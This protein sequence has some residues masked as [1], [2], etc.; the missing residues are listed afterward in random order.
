MSARTDWEMH[1][2]SEAAVR[3]FAARVRGT[4]IQP[5]DEEYDPARRVWNAAVDRHPALLVRPREVPDVIEAVSFARTYDLPLAVR[6]G[7]HSPAGYGTADL[8]LVVDLSAMKRLDVD[9]DRRV[10]SAEAG[11]TWGEYNARAHEKGLATPGGDVGAVGI[12]GLTL[13]GGMG[14]L[15][16]KHG[17]TIDNLVEVDIVTTDGRRLTA[18]A[19]AEQDLFWALRGGGGNFGIA[20]GFRYRL[21]PV[22]TILGGAI[23]YPATRDGLRAYADAT[24][25]APD[26]LTTIT[27]VSNAPPLPFIPAAA[28]GTPVHLILPCYTG[29]LDAGQH[30]LA[31]FRKLAGGTPLADTTA[32]M[33]Y[34]ALYELTNMAAVRRPHLIKNAFIRELSDD[35]I[36]IILDFVNRVT[37]PFGMIALRELGGAMA[38]VPADGT[39]FAH[40]DKA[41]YIAADSSWEEEPSPERHIAWAE[42]F[43]KAVA[44]HTDGAYAGFM[45]DE[46]DAR[47]RAAYP[48]ATYTRL[49]AIKRR[50]DPDNVLRLNPNIQPA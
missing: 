40:R 39:A 49:A 33:P 1:G 31:P 32:P 3:S 8:G 5:G 38:R 23:V 29:D 4:V 36:E 24:A 6:G 11:L 50:Y 22:G 44:P 15:M 14:W 17:M 20:T 16:R 34:P 9:P 21:Q 26:E 18:S 46:G 35:T 19:E 30:A 37:S 13:S 43:W 7:G 27:F 12:A 25:S 47:V 2:L 41:F 28:H 48:G 42:A 45:G 10:A